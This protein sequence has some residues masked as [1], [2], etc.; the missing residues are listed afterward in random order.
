MQKRGKKMNDLED[1]QLL[2]SENCDEVKE[3]LLDKNRKYGNSAFNPLR[4]FSK[5]D[6]LEQLKVR[7]DDKFSRLL[8]MAEDEDEDVLK[9]IIGYLIIYKIQLKRV[10]GGF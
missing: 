10:R 2:I 4:L 3:M 9:D 1:M 5:A 8:N 7:L 6:P